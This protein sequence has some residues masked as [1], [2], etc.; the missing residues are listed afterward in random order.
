M[1]CER[2]LRHNAVSL[3]PGRSTKVTAAPAA[4][5]AWIYW[6]AEAPDVSAQLIAF[7]RFMT[8][9]ACQKHEPKG[10]GAG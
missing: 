2:A 7:V 9:G 1:V 6:T 4:T 3:T 5:T 10:Y 8:A